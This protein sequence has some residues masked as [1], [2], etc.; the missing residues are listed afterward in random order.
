MTLIAFNV[1]MSF[2][3]K[4]FNGITANTDSIKSHPIKHTSLGHKL[5]VT[6][7]RICKN[8]HL[9]RKQANNLYHFLKKFMY[10]TYIKPILCFL[11]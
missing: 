11:P 8:A 7:S 4:Y 1:N 9:I 5:N 3:A 6:Y 10:I 2:Q